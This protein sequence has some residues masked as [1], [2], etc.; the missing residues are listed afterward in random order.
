MSP[1]AFAFMVA[2]GVFV[3]LQLLAHFWVYALFFGQLQKTV[4]TI[5]SRRQRTLDLLAS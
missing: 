1:M 4:H 5:S 3:W 2:A